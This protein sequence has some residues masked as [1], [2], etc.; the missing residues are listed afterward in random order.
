MTLPPGITARVLRKLELHEQIVHASTHRELRDLGDGTLL[1]DPDDSEPFWN[2]LQGVRWPHETAAFVRRLDEVVTLFATLNRLPH[3]LAL[4]A[5]NQPENLV[6]RLVAEGFE[7]VGRGYVMVLVDPGPALAL[8]RRATGP[9]VT[10]HRLRGLTTEQARRMAPEVASVAGEAFGIH[11]G[12]R[13]AFLQQTFDGLVN[14]RASYVLARVQGEPASVALRTP[15]DGASYL[16][17]IGTRV[18]YRGRGLGTLVT[19][20]AVTDAVAGRSRWTYLG[21]FAENHL[22]RSVYERLGFAIAGSSSAD[23]LLIR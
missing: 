20:A 3:V 12:R 11:P 23:L 22:A 2:R 9:D 7:E 4:P 21:V 14:G 16:S 5:F 6:E 1:H 19:A 18:P 13:A 10:L 8:A 17:S 15:F